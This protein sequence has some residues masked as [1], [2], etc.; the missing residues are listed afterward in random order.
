MNTMDKET[1][2][3]SRDHELD[4]SMAVEKAQDFMRKIVGNL[5]AVQFRLESVQENGLETRYNVICSVVRDIGAE[6]EYYIIKVDVE[7]GLIVQPIGKGKLTG[8][9]IEF[10]EFEVDPAWLK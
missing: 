1:E 9:K 7:S 10:E 4:V 5:L 8:N 6:K 2:K 3:K